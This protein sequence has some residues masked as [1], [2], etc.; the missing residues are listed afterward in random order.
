MSCSIR[1]SHSDSYRLVH[2]ATVAPSKVRQVCSRMTSIRYSISWQCWFIEIAGL[3]LLLQLL[4]QVPKYAGDAFLHLMAT[5]LA[6]S[7]NTVLQHETTPSL[8]IEGMLHTLPLTVAP[9]SHLADSRLLW[10]ITFYDSRLNTVRTKSMN[11]CFSLFL[12][13]SLL[14]LIL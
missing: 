12:S 13:L 1:F 8:A 6:T 2:Y 5:P 7:L 14:S 4:P 9:F 10:S 11:V 3:L